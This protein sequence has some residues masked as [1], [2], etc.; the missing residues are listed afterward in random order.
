MKKQLVKNIA[1]AVKFSNDPSIRRKQAVASVMFGTLALV[2]AFE[3]GTAVVH[4]AE[5]AVNGV[6][7]NVHQAGESGKFSKFHLNEHLEDAKIDP[8]T[9]TM[10]TVQATDTVP[11]QLARDMHAKDV[12]LVAGEIN[13]QVGGE[14]SMEPGE[15]VVIPNDQLGTPVEASNR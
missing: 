2:G 12:R 9:V 7:D 10:R 1:P 5:D 4:V 3:A 6:K 8:T 13:S 15:V 11:Y 14:R